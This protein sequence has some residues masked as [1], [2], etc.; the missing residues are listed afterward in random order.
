ML[1]EALPADVVRCVCSQLRGDRAALLAL[2]AVSSRLCRL[3]RSSGAWRMHLH[4]ALQRAMGEEE[5]AVRLPALAHLL[6]TARGDCAVLAPLLSSA[7]RVSSSAVSYVA[8]RP[9]VAELAWELGARGRRDLLMLGA[10]HGEPALCD[11]ALRGI[12]GHMAEMQA[13]GADEALMVVVLAGEPRSLALRLIAAGADVASRNNVVLMTAA[14]KGLTDVVEA[15][16]A[17]P[18]ERGVDVNVGSGH[19]LTWAAHMGH[20][21]IVRLL[22][23]HGGTAPRLVVD[24]VRR[25]ARIAVLE[26]LVNVPSFDADEC[27][28]ALLAAAAADDAPTAALLIRTANEQFGG[29]TPDD[30][31]ALFR[32]AVGHG[33]LAVCGILVQHPAVSTLPHKDLRRAVAAAASEKADELLELMVSTHLV[34]RAELD[35]VLHALSP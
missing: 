6:E 28:E 27:H 30:F 33:A 32:Q 31:A 10:R 2:S 18:P 21:A 9:D 29:P 14:Q 7:P 25:K 16:L 23:A 22:I 5:G 12:E 24:A 3:V 26:A 34:E 4:G 8:Q 11:V 15:L 19:A 13:V 17:L 20:E 35:A 1:L